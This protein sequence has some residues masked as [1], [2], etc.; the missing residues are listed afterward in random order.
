[1]T[2]KKFFAII[3]SYFG[4]KPKQTPTIPTPAEVPLT[5]DTTGPLVDPP[6]TEQWMHDHAESEECGVERELKIICRPMFW[7]GVSGGWW[8]ISSLAMKH[9]QRDTAGIRCDDW[10][11]G[12]YA[13]HVRGSTSIE[14]QCNDPQPKLE[15]TGNRNLTKFV[16]VEV[17]HA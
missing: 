16:L 17:R 11:E 13:Y 7:R 9:V 2:W 8:V 3:L 10:T 12:G 15:V 1:M 6:V 14:P 4:Q 5:V